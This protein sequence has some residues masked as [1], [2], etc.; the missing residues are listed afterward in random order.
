[1]E[2]KIVKILFWSGFTLIIFGLFGHPIMIGLFLIIMAFMFG[3]AINSEKRK[4]EEKNEER[5]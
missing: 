5:N 2:N 4:N 1:M 3:A